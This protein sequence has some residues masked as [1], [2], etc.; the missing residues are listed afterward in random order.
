MFKSANKKGL[1]IASEGSRGG[2]WAAGAR[3]RSLAVLQR[4]CKAG[5]GTWVFLEGDG[6]ELLTRGGFR[7]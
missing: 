7:G 6:L 3:E 2:F 4:P 1:R 5:I